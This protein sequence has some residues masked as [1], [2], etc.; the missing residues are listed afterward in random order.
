[1]PCVVPLPKTC[2]VAAQTG[3]GDNP[4]ATPG[5][6]AAPEQVAGELDLICRKNFDAWGLLKG[7]QPLSGEL[8][9][10][11]ATTWGFLKDLRVCRG[12]ADRLF[13]AGNR[14]PGWMQNKTFLV[15]SHS[16]CGVDRQCQLE[17]VQETGAKVI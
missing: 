1:M 11:Y 2:R 16:G 5:L 7:L 15:D 13:L 17:V 8:L 3:K 9:K 12:S 14:W 4:R 6:S 10:R